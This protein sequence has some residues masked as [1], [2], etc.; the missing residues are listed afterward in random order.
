MNDFSMLEFLFHEKRDV[1]MLFFVKGNVSCPSLMKQMGRTFGDNTPLDHVYQNLNVTQIMHK[2]NE[3]NPLP[4]L[5]EEARIGKDA[6][7]LTNKENLKYF[8]PTRSL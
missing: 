1:F 7:L 6:L 5:R 2:P 4:S 3:W 8:L